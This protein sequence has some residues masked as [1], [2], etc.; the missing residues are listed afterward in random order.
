MVSCGAELM[1]TGAINAAAMM[2]VTGSPLVPTMPV[3]AQAT[4]T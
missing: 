1:S 4:S 2:F 3:P